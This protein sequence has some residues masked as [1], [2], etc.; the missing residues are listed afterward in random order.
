MAAPQLHEERS[1]FE[2]NRMNFIIEASSKEECF[3][4][5]DQLKQKYPNISVNDPILS[6]NGSFLAWGHY[7][8]E[9]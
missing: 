1:K 5:R 7:M 9:N 3:N 4:I 2:E 8:K 6:G